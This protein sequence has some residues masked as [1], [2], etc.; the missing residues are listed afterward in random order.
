MDK[1]RYYPYSD[2][3]KETFGERVFKITIDGGFS[4]PNRDGTISKGGCI[5]CDEIGS[6]SMGHDASLSVEKQVREGISYL[7]K[8]HKVNKFLAYF[9]AFTNTY[10]PVNELKKIYDGAFCDSSVVGISIGTRPD[11]VEDEKLDLIS[12]YPYPQLE[13]GLQTIHDETLKIINRG[14]D[15]KTFENAYIRAKKRG[16]N[17]CVHLI[18][19]LPNE[20][21]KMMLETAKRMGELEVDGIKF[22]SLTILKGS[23]LEKI[24]D[25]IRLLTEDEYAN[26]VAESIAYLSPKTTIQRVAGSGLRSLTLEPKW[27][28]HKFHTQNLIDRIM[29]EK[30][31]YQGDKLNMF[32]SK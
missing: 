7:Q 2:Y 26:L 23:K 19:G 4:C 17:V 15:Y 12:S 5:F 29:W 32:L 14:H 10:K 28:N 8:R 31:I 3:L 25:N 11:C 20:T 6:F 21:R 1:K 30:N 27:I 22:H 13:F 16:I 18:F 24:K 9:Q